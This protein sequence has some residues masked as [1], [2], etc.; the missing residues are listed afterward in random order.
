MNN[1]IYIGDTDVG[2]GVFAKRLIKKGEKILKLA[3]RIIDAR[4][5]TKEKSRRGDPFQV[6]D[7]KYIDLKKPGIFVNHSCNPNAGIK[8]NTIL[9]A[10]KNIKR[11]EEIRYDY[12]LTMD[13]SE[14]AM[15]CKCRQKNCRKFIK[16]FKFLPKKLRK[17]YLRLEIVQ[18]FIAEKSAF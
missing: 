10:L 15:R 8:N 12:S 13:G 2:R 6:S 14:W 7:K 9:V 1:K 16:D 11:R 18:K 17:K 3:G 4:Q 5:I